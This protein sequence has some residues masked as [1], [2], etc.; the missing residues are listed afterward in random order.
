MP[1]LVTKK[2]RINYLLQ[3]LANP[4]FDKIREK[5]R[6][7]NDKAISFL[8]WICETNTDNVALCQL[9]KHYKR[10]ALSFLTGNYQVTEK[11]D[12]LKKDNSKVKYEKLN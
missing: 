6:N 4:K 12:S 3:F 1:F 8:D 5:L 9:I 11:N 2:G 7:N 10:Y